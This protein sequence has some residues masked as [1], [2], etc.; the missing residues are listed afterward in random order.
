MT[1]MCGGLVKL[2]LCM[3]GISDGVVGGRWPVVASV[4]CHKMSMS[5]IMAMVG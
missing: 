4:C 5:T 1:L 2:F 3:E